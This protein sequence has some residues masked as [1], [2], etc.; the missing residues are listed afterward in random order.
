MA[1]PASPSPPH[2]GKAG[3][4]HVDIRGAAGKIHVPVKN[5][6]GATA[7]GG[8]MRSQARKEKGRKP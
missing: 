7:V 8:A 6:L 3:D 2:R 1:R 5:D 4:R